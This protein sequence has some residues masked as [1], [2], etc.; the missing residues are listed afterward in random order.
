MRRLL[1]AFIR[2]IAKL[3][4]KK[5]LESFLVFS[6]KAINV[7]LYQH[8]LV[9]LGAAGGYNSHVGGE[10][11]FIEKVLPGLIAGE[12]SPVFFDVGANIGEYSIQLRKVF[13]TARIY[14]F[15]PV[16]YTYDL[17]AAGTFSNEI[18]CFNIGFSDASGKGVIFNST[19]KANTEFA[20][21][22]QDAFREIFTGEADM[23][24]NEFVMETI[25][26]FCCLN[27]I[28]RID[29]LKIDVEGHEFSVL[30][31][32]HDMISNGAVKVVQFEFNAHNVYS[33]VFLRDYYVLLDDFEF[34]RLLPGGIARLG[35]YNSSNEIFFW[36]NIVAIRKDICHLVDQQIVQQFW[37]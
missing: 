32:A 11:F 3:T 25:G 28:I 33:R 12:E 5:N 22:Y 24:R 18:S 2:L 16:K 8:G 15:E 36:Q 23:V 34:F 20:T 17:L 29:F 14:A 19:N 35:S 21:I 4:G 30:K 13:K 6:A 9:Q 10:R 27:G 37:Q 1:S 31:G 7:N 26:N